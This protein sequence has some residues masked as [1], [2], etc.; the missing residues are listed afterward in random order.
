L[1]EDIIKAEFQVKTNFPDADIWLQTRGTEFNVGKP[2]KQF[3]SVQG[4]YNY[5]IKL[6][7]GWN[8]DY[9]FKQLADLYKRGHWKI[10]SY[11]SLLLQ[12]IRKDD[13]LQVLDKLE[14]KEDYTDETSE[15]FQEIYE[16]WLT[17]SKAVAEMLEGH[18]SELVRE[19]REIKRFIEK[20][21]G[22][23]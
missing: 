20:L 23:R 4:K 22:M 19:G 1:W 5:G 2:L 18:S 17:Y 8:K 9:V 15:K 13:I 7:E 14:N 16:N 11:G 6:P 21:E 3:S 10:H 12:H